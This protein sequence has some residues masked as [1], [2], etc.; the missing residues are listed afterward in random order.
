MDERWQDR[1]FVGHVSLWNR[2]VLYGANAMHWAL[3]VRAFGWWWCFHPT[4]R[5]FGGCWPW[6]VYASRDA[7]PSVE[8]CLF[9]WGSYD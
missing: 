3:N 5:T 7:T 6:Y 2:I 9:R 1:W 8:K 4:T